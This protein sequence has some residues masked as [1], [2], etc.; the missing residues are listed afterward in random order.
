MIDAGRSFSGHEKSVTAALLIDSAASIDGTPRMV[1]ASLDGTARLWSVSTGVEL[2]RYVGHVSGVTDVVVDSSGYMM[3]SGLDN[4]VL[5]L[6]M[7]DRVELW[8]PETYD[9][10]VEQQAG[11]LD[12]FAHR[13]FG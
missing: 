12:Q 2:K 5:L 13:I 7:S 10:S 9:R 8:D 6:G 1:S 11:D 3:S 4:A